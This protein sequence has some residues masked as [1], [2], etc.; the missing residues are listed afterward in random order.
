[1]ALLCL[2]LALAGGSDR[3]Q[4]PSNRYSTHALTQITGKLYKPIVWRRSVSWI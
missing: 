1:L 2:A 4:S 3:T